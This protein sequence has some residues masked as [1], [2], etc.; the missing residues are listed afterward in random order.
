MQKSL[1][2]GVYLYLRSHSMHLLR[3]AAKNHQ[4]T[5]AMEASMILEETLRPA[6]NCG[7][8]PDDAEG[9]DKYNANGLYVNL[10]EELLALLRLLAERNYRS[11]AGEVAYVL[12]SV[13]SLTENQAEVIAPKL[14][15]ILKFK[16]KVQLPK[17]AR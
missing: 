7:K 10:S 16:P 15:P 1:K 13:L 3:E 4:R 17:S 9:T 5:P 2:K 6:R 12:E 8:G 14:K 11:L